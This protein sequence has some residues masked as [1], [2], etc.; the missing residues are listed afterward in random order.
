MQIPQ[1]NIRG[2]KWL[3][4][5]EQRNRTAVAGHVHADRQFANQEILVFIERNGEGGLA[6]RLRHVVL[7]FK[8]RSE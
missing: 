2:G 8:K 5:R 3:V 1:L 4:Q 6:L 7:L